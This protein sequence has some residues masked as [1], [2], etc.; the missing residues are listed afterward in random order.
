MA[1]VL[2][3]VQRL[4]K[5]VQ[6]TN[7]HVDWVVESTLDK[8]LDRERQKLRQQLARLQSQT[9]GFEVRYGWSSEEFYPRF[10]RCELG[11]DMDLIEWSA[12][13]EMIA[14]LKH[15]IAILEEG[16]ERWQ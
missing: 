13:V 4:E 11:D 12:T 15:A 1:A 10:E 9:A 7:G 3:K 2:E 5:Y 16:T 14:N 6:A 8:L